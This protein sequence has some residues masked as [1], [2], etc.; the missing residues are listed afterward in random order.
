MSTRKSSK[1]QKSNANLVPLYMYVALF[2]LTSDGTW[3]RH[4]YTVSDRKAIRNAY[5]PV[6]RI[7]CTQVRA[8]LADSPDGKV[9]L[10]L[11][12]EGVAQVVEKLDAVSGV[13]LPEAEKILKAKARIERM[14]AYKLAVPEVS[15]VVLCAGYDT[16]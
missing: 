6:E 3:K 13:T 4:Q 9:K 8:M 14:V 7:D 16:K 2:V 10:P 15:K 12:R 1:S 5:L 11:T